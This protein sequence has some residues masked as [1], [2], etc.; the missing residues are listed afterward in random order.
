MKE[1]NKIDTGCSIQ[2]EKA[3]VAQI[4]ASAISEVDG[5][6]LI[7]QDLSSW[8]RNLIGQKVTPGIKVKSDKESNQTTVYA[9]VMVRSGLNISDIARQVQEAIRQAIEKTIDGIDLKDVNVIIHGIER[10]E[11]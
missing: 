6:S 10:G 1:V 5:V 7:Q 2:V 4:A 8:L 9:R 3:V 11:T